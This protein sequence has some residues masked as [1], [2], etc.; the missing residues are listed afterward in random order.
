MLVT[1]FLA[2]NLPL[3]S[4]FHILCL[5]SLLPP[6]S[7]RSRVIFLLVFLLHGTQHNKLARLAV[8][9]LAC[10]SSTSSLDLW[11]VW[12]HTLTASIPP[13]AVPN[14]GQ[15]N[16]A[17]SSQI[18]QTCQLFQRRLGRSHQSKFSVLHTDCSSPRLLC[19][20]AIANLHGWYR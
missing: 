4:P 1:L 17:S 19:H 15:A 8:E 20:T 13:N 14:H 6:H 9:P 7:Q 5:P 11:A 3:S 16:R 2:A 12:R 18:P 10:T